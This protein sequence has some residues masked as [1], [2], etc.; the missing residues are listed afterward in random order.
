M[1]AVPLA[2]MM[3]DNEYG[4]H[5]VSR[6]SEAS[7]KLLNFCNLKQLIIMNMWFEKKWHHLTIWKHS[8]MKDSHMI[9]YVIIRADQQ[10]LCMDVQ[11]IAT[12]PTV[13]LTTL[14]SGPR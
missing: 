6:C 7:E 4:R 3:Y 8:A 9:D 10:V 12:R 14:W 1:W 2:T 13:G 5:I 11:V